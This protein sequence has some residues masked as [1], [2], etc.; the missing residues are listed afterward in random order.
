[1]ST[2]GSLMSP[3]QQPNTVVGRFGVAAVA[4]MAALMLT[5]GVAGTTDAASTEAATHLSVGNFTPVVGT[6]VPG[7]LGKKW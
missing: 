7:T 2:K 5:G 1:M 4:V 3:A 6:N